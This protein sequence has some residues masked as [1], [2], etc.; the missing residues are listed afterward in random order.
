MQEFTNPM[1]GMNTEVPV[2]PYLWTA[3]V[4]VTHVMVQMWGGGG[5][6]GSADIT[7]SCFGFG[8]GGG[9]YSQSVI[10]VTPGTVYAINVG[11][12]GQTDQRGGNMSSMEA[13]GN[14]LIYAG[15]AGCSTGGETN[16]LAASQPIT[17]VR[18]GAD[19]SASAGGPAFGAEF[20]PGPDGNKTGRGANWADPASHAFGGYVLL[21]W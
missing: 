7:S 16:T 2:A 13:G 3:P 1:P 19:A 6:A 17:I 15:G 21:T 20:C 18:K 5:G 8:G 14:I 12:G 4:G 10:S 9:A 11:G